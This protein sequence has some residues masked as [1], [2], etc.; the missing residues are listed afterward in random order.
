MVTYYCFFRRDASSPSKL[1]SSATTD[2]RGGDRDPAGTSDKNVA[3]AA[4]ENDHIDPY[5]TSRAVLDQL[6]RAKNEAA[7]DP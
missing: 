6:K 4:D 3:L 2:S 7:S 5:F 1:I